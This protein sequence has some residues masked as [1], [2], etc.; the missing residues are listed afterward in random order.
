MRLCGDWSVVARCDERGRFLRAMGSEFTI[1]VDCVGYRAR[2]ICA[3]IPSVILLQEKKTSARKIFSPLLTCRCGPSVTTTGAGTAAAA[4]AT[5]TH[6][7][8]CG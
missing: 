7:K 8:S 2:G 1:P 5:V 4:A 3:N 6:E